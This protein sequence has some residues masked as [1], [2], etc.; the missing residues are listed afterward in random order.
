[1]SGRRTATARRWPSGST[2]IVAVCVPVL[3]ASLAVS[4]VTTN[5]TVP[6]TYAYDKQHTLTVGELI[7]S[8][9]SGLGLTS[10]EDASSGTVLLGSGNA[11]EWL[12]NSKNQTTSGGGANLNG[13]GGNDCMV[14]GGVRSGV[15]LTVGGGAGTDDC[16]D[17]PGPG[18]YTRNSCANATFFHAPYVTVT[19]NSPAFS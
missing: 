14:P 2:L 3:I 19:T 7:M 15:T 6:T 4:A 5:V 16:F 10:I 17:G 8:Q 12:W 18:S 9:C 11:T 1:M 13:G